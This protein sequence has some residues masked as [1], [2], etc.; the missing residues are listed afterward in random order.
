MPLMMR[1]GLFSLQSIVELQPDFIKIDRSLISGI[2]RD[3]MKEHIVHTFTELAAKMDI[4]L[5]A[6]GIEE[7]EELAHMKAWAS[8]MR[9]AIFLAGRSRH[10]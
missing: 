2:H 4:S 8:N 10:W 9:K 5:V 6:E 1:S 7:Q 3:P